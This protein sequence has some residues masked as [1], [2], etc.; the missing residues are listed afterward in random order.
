MSRLLVLSS[1]PGV[2]STEFRVLPFAERL[3]GEG[4]T[5]VLRHSWPRLY[6]Q[7]RWLGFRGSNLARRSLRRL[8]AALARLGRFDAVF[9]ERQ[10]FDDETTD[11]E[12]RLRRAARRLVFDVD[13]AVHLGREG[14]FARLWGSADVVLAGNPLLMEA[15]AE[16]CGDVRFMPTVVDAD[17]FAY[18]EP[19]DRTPVVIGWMGT[20]SNLPGVAG[21]R[22][23]IERVAAGRDVRLRIVSNRSPAWEEFRG[24]SLPVET[25]EWSRETETDAVAGFD[26]GLMPLPDTVWS[27]G[28]CGLKLIQYLSAG[29]ASVASPAG[30]NKTIAAG[31]AA[32]TAESTDE[33]ADALARLVGSVEARREHARV[34]RRR[35]EEDYSLAAWYDRWK[36]AV[37]G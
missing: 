3:R 23:A 34:G 33:W 29:V 8:D 7:K 37:F 17:R 16:H 14:K 27:R 15:A 2:P 21:L 36:A 25:L 1:G 13:D 35:V 6:T 20:S 9:V 19:P 18:R 32:L 10:L 22:P 24:W 4:H 30:V 26:V 28:K 11:V 12:A 31:G 5:V